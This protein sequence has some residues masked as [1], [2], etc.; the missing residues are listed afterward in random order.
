MSNLRLY[1]Y[2]NMNLFSDGFDFGHLS[3]LLPPDEYEN[4]ISQSILARQ[5]ILKNLGNNSSSA[6]GNSGFDLL[7]GS[8]SLPYFRKISSLIARHYYPHLNY[9]HYDW[10]DIDSF[11]LYRAQQ[12]IGR[13][14]D[15]QKSDRLC[16]VLIYFS[17]D[18]I[19]GSGGGELKLWSFQGD[20][21]QVSPTLGN[22]VILDLSQNDPAHEVVEVTGSYHRYT[23]IRFLESE[24]MI[25]YLSA[26]KERFKKILET[27]KLLE[28]ERS[29]SSM[30]KIKNQ[31][32]DREIIELRRVLKEIRRKTLL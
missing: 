26:G 15:G 25:P 21:Y 17:E 14:R 7:N 4:F 18:P 23:Y 8:S 2:K 12:F 20:V 32:L 13:H 24:L 28:E 27:E 5:D 9:D 16:A 22:Y 6:P 3:L 31:K 10:G 1:I 19:P 11:S 30:M 29:L